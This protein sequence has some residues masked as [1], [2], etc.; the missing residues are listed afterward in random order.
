MCV[1]DELGE[2]VQP[3]NLDM[4][5]SLLQ[6]VSDAEDLLNRMIC[7]RND[8]IIPILKVLGATG[9]NIDRV[10]I[11]GGNVDI[12]RSGTNWEKDYSF[13]LSIFISNDP[14][15]AAN[16]YMERQE[17]AKKKAEYEAKLAQLKKLQDELL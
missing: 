4:F 15:K 2:Q 7:R 1:K 10:R 14:I 5:S 6:D 11:E 8:F 17:L 16:L 9:R 3:S 13:P 12:T